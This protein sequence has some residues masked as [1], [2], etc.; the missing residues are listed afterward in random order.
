MISP[1]PVLQPE[2]IPGHHVLAVPADVTAAEVRILAETRWRACRKDDAGGLVVS[3]YSGLDGPFRLTDELSTQIGFPPG[4][5]RAFVATT[6]RE[7]GDPPFPGASDPSGI[8]RA[9][10]DA[11]P[12]RE[13]ARVVDWLLAA[14]RRLG[15]AVRLDH[16]GMVLIPRA[17]AAIDLT[18]YSNL[19]LEPDAALTVVRSVA[20]EFRLA[21]DTHAWNGPAGA[22]TRTVGA[23]ADQVRAISPWPVHASNALSDAGRRILHSEADAHDAA[24]L[25]RNPVLDRYAVVAD[26][27]AAGTA[28]LEVCGGG[29]PPALRTVAWTELGVVAYALRWDP[30]NPDDRLVEFPSRAQRAE[31]AAAAR[32][33][34][35]LAL[36]VYS[37]TG[38]EILDADGFPVDPADV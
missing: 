1:D 12:I 8:A 37:A 30:A 34:G 4:L 22:E 36:A 13:E 19:W 5:P 14:A 6:L 15:G 24:A 9:F 18:V 33:L 23:H 17:D 3:K 27:G 16:W 26:F 11:L 10:P 38:I 29:A 7:R 20:P 32:T 35:R 28:W 2:G 21:M 25:S 31:R